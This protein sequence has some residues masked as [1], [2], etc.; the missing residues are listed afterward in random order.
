V[1]LLIEFTT[2]SN[3]RPEIIGNKEQRRIA[4]KIEMT[5]QSFSMPL[6]QLEGRET[7]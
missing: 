4:L 1:V 7:I 5:M 6:H 2:S 3:K